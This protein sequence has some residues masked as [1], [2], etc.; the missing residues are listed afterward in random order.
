MKKLLYRHETY[1]LLVIIVLAIVITAINP[2]FFTVENLF[3]LLKSTSLMGTFAIGMLFVLISGGI[4]MSFT[5]VATV[6]GYTIAVL[7]LKHGDSMNMALVFLVAGGLGILLG[8]LNAVFIYFFKIPSIIT[9][10]ATQNIFYGL[11]TVV[12]EGK[13]LYGFPEWFDEFSSI[14]VFT[15]YSETGAPY[16]LSIITVIWFVLLV[17]S[18]FILKHTVLGRSIY[19]MGGNIGSAQRAGFNIFGLTLFVYGYMGLMAGI[20]SVIQALLVQTVAPNSLVGK[21]MDVIAAVVLGGA[22]LMG[23]TGSIPGMILGV[24]LIAILSNGL[25]LMRVP[26]Q[27]YEVVIGLVIIISVGVSAYRRKKITRKRVITESN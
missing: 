24:S 11:L 13:W 17:I 10:I 27:W 9:T 26:S 20:G 8:M 12:S 23:G 6:T 19:A 3:D 25:T 4:D 2:S 7:L 16:G 22:S 18:W 15:L 5:A 21:E 1:V 14:R